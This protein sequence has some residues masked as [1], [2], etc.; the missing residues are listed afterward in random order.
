MGNYRLKRLLCDHSGDRLEAVSMA[1]AL[2]MK[3]C[4]RDL[5]VAVHWLGH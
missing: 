2:A 1:A 4:G 3:L 5:L